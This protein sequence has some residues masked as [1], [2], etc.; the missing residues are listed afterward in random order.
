MVQAGSRW[1]ELECLSAAWA[2][3]KCRQFIEGLVTDH[4]PL[5]PILNDYSLDKLYNPR[6]LHLRLK[7]QRY[8]FR[9]RWVRGK[10]NLDADALSRAPVD[11]ASPNDELVEGGHPL[12]QQERPSSVR[13]IALTFLL[14]TRFW[15]ESK[16]QRLKT[17]K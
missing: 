15:T 14:Q 11:I 13:S 5:T 16:R 8:Q 6:I 1:I 4:R 7:M 17:N 9:A 2:M 12:F 3:H 10:D